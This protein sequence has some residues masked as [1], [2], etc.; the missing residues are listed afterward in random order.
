MEY[1]CFK[2]KVKPV[3]FEKANPCSCVKNPPPGR[4]RVKF[5][6]KRH[7]ESKQPAAPKVGMQKSRPA[8]AG[9]SQQ[10]KEPAQEI[11][12][13]ELQIVTAGKRFALSFAEI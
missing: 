8:M 2:V 9:W 6:P 5:S 13:S 10:P 1:H 11:L 7:I 3:L 12:C 4:V